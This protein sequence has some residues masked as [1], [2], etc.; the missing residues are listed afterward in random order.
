[1]AKADSRDAHQREAVEKHLI[2]YGG[3]FA[4][5][6]IH[7][8][9]GSYVYD[10]DGRAILDFTSGQ[11]CAIL[12]HNHPDIL[13]AMQKSMDEVIHLFSG[14]LSPPVV[15]LAS[16]LAELLPVGLSKTLL[17]N[18]GS[19]SNEAALRMAKL[20]TGGFEVVGFADAWHGMTAYSHWF[21]I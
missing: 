14:M 2:R 3:E 17:V 16:A 19:E 5:F 13:A 7:R 21:I 6:F 10:Q 11:M 15:E 8:A 20:H 18:T 9:K 4:P 12:G 1:M